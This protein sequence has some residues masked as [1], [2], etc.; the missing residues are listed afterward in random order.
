MGQGKGIAERSVPKD[1]QTC[2]SSSSRMT[3]IKQY[4]NIVSLPDKP[5]GPVQW[6]PERFLGKTWSWCLGQA[7]GQ[8]NRSCLSLVLSNRSTGS[9]G[10]TQADWTI[11]LGGWLQEPWLGASGCIQGGWSRC[12][13]QNSVLNFNPSVG[14]SRQRSQNAYW[15]VLGRALR[16][17]LL[18]CLMSMLCSDICSW[19]TSVTA[20]MGKYSGQKKIFLCLY[21]VVF[22]SVHV[23]QALQNVSNLA[24]KNRIGSSLVYY[25]Q[26]RETL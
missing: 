6:L 13:Q 8:R 23:P 26:W 9:N 15:H 11:C 1:R 24:H 20:Q 7:P 12:P 3:L 5:N 4:H 17:I 18:I 25:C 22:P 16:D 21:A 14:R 2:A 10:C 19:P